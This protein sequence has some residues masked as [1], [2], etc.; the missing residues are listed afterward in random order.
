MVFSSIT[1][2]LYFLPVSIVG[3]FIFSFSRV[4]Q[5]MW[6]LTVSLLFYA[7]GE[8]VFVFLMIGSIFA[9]WIFGLLV[10]KFD[11]NIKAKKVVLFIS[12]AANIGFLG[13]FKYTNFIVDTLYD[14]IGW[15]RLLDV[16]TIALPIGISFFTFQAMSYVIDVYRKDAEVQKNPFY[17]G[18][19]VSFFPQLVAGPIVRYSTI[20]EQIKN[21]KT[22]F[23]MFS[24]GCCRFAIGL[25]KKIII[26]NNMAIIADKVFELGTA[27]SDVIKV[28][29]M[30]AWVGAVAY[31]FQLYY[32]FSSY[33]DMAIGLGKM[34]GFKYEENFNYP[35]ISKSIREFMSRWHIS[36]GTWFNQYVYR[37]LGGSRVVNKDKM[38]RNLFVVWLLTGVWHGAAWTYIWWGLYFFILILIEKVIMLEKWQGHRLGRRV[39]TLVAVVIA[40]VIFRSEDMHHCSKMLL[41]MVGMNGNGIYSDMAVMFVKEYWMIFAAAVACMLPLKKYFLRW[42]GERKLNTGVKVMGSFVYIVGLCALLFFCVV[43]LAKGGYNPFIYFNF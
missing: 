7:W 20:A 41:N 35:F 43:V 1:F 18:L 27:G 30:L 21:R 33:S 19:Y 17:L 29:L 5:N 26:S 36:L 39:Y 42:L 4:F 28:P 13:V 32:D 9:N 8:P 11:K 23:D 14:A 37:P 24:D 15:K 16:P 25:V 22:T 10:H 34:F 6:L 2:L 31:T 40:M 3:Y 38:V 12:C